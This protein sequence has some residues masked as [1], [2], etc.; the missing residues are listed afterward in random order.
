MFGKLLVNIRTS[1]E[2]VLTS[3]LG[4]ITDTSCDNRYLY[5][6]TVD[7]SI[8]KALTKKDNLEVLNANLKKFT[9]LTVMPRLIEKESI[10]DIEK[11]LKEK[12]KGL[13]NI[14]D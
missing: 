9:H 14:I 13:L 3:I 10:V 6:N 7:N 1:N 4:N 2:I 12:F 5:I 11:I 8:Y